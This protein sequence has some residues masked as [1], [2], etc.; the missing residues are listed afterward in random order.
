M[1]A[2]G[3]G[4]MPG[5]LRLGI[6]FLRA[7]APG[8]PAALSYAAVLPFLVLAATIGAGG[9]GPV[10]QGEAAAALRGWGATLLA[11]LGG[12]RWGLGMRQPGPSQLWAVP[13][14]VAAVVGWVAL[15][16]P[17]Q[18]GISVMAAAFAAQGAFDVW[19]AERGVLPPWYARLRLRAT[20][21][22]VVLLAAAVL[23]LSA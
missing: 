15:L 5:R 17:D 1:P 10:D 11:F 4:A 21:L 9:W 18:P 6:D 3:K 16:L 19:G 23:A 20:V 14:A 7:E 22:T 12:V 2:I 8:L 13:G